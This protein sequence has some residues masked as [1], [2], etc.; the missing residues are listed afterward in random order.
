[1]TINRGGIMSRIVP[2]TGHAVA[3]FAALASIA[4]VSAPIE[5]ALGNEPSTPVTV[6]SNID[7][8][9]RIAYQSDKF[10][11]NCILNFCEFS[12]PEVPRGHRLVI[13]HVSG[14]LQFR[15][16]AD[17]VGVRLRI[18]EGGGAI[19]LSAFFA[20]LGGS[21][22]FPRGSSLFDQPVLAYVDP[23]DI[24]S[25]TPGVG[26]FVDV[27]VRGGTFGGVV[28]RVTVTGYLLDC[29][30]SPCAPIAQ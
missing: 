21:E 28:Q 8:R 30:A 19:L 10:N 22:F 4:I 25:T 14:D 3:M 5:R 24:P 20:P 29:T 9:G 1:M 13:L 7:D 15:E 12:F 16:N 11:N 23:A 2:L 27:V 18:G 26:Y 6:V 17:S